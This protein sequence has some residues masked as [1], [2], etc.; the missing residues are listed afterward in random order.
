MSSSLER[1]ENAR[2]NANFAMQNNTA[3]AFKKLAKA[4][5]QG[6]R[7]AG[8]LVPIGYEDDDMS[9]FNNDG[10]CDYEQ[11]DNT[12]NCAAIELDESGELQRCNPEKKNKGKGKDGNGMS[13]KT[14][15]PLM[16]NQTCWFSRNNWMTVTA[17]LRMTC[18]R[19]AGISKLS[20]KLFPIL[21]RLVYCYMQ[22]MGEIAV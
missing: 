9:G 3:K 10:I 14:A 17:Q 13:L 19:L 6:R 21:T 8:H 11:G 4:G 22:K 2:H 15:R 20:M 1:I 7:E 18:S 16:K 5:V 12:A